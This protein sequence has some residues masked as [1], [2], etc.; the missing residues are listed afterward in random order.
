VLQRI[1]VVIIDVSLSTGG[2]VGN[3]HTAITVVTAYRR[4]S[5]KCSI[6]LRLFRYL[7]VEDLETAVLC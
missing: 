3:C 6:A 5:W 1:L 7:Q 4:I 2:G